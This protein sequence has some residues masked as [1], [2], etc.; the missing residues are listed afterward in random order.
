MS[1]LSEE[2]KQKMIKAPIKKIDLPFKMLT[3]KDLY[4]HKN[5]T[6]K[7]LVNQ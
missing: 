1:D 5:T 4:M 7:I 2:I 6:N 3:I